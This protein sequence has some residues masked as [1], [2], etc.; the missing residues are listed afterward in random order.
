MSNVTEQ[1]DRIAVVDFG[2]QYAHLIASKVRRIGVLAEIRQPTDP[3]E[4]Y[5]PYRGVIISGSPALASRGED[6]DYDRR[7]LD[8]DV[9]IVGFCF[10]HQE[11]AKHYGGR[12]EH[13]GREYGFARLSITAQ[14]PVF[15]GMGPE[16]TVWMSHQDAVVEVG[17]G[18]SEIGYSTLVEDGTVHRFAAIADE[19]RRRYG[20]QYHPEVD[21]TEHGEDMIRNFVIDVCGCR[22]TWR[23][24][25]FAESEIEEIRR[26]VGD[27]QVLLLVSG[28]VDS[29]VCAVL[30]GRALGPDHLRLL[31]IDNGLMRKGESRK[32]LERFERFGLGGNLHFVDASD[33][34]LDALEGL[35]EPEEKRRAIGNT[36]VQVFEQE[37]VRWIDG[38]VVLA[39]GTIYPDTIETGGTDRADVIKTHHNRVP[40]VEEMIAAGRVVEPIRD[41]YKVEVR[42]LGAELGLDESLLERHPFP[43]PGLG[44][45]LLCADAPP[46]G[47]EE[48]ERTTNLREVLAR[49]GLEGRL[50]PIRSVGVKADL[51]CY[52]LPVVL[53]GEAPDWSAATRAAGAVFKEVEHVN[54]C[55]LDLTGGPVESLELVPAHLTRER[56]DLLREADALIM[57][58]LGRHGLLRSIWQCPTVLAPLRRNRGGDEYVIVR[59]V[60]SARAMTA[61]PARLAEDLVRE[62]REGILALPG[63]SGLGLDVTTKPPGTIEWE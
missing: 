34:F 45:R 15:R 13:T 46:E 41:L 6:E 31:H 24:S 10:G 48:A 44:V 38:D 52:E 8:L 47:F 50:V 58:G 57:E 27:R 42:E 19:E 21:D 36:F 20:F 26:T 49:F 28:G 54:R 11:I 17:E 63:V 61:A 53:H 59:P 1:H 4:A 56:L 14:S 60:H 5:A 32:V 25:A 35:T 2:G 7:I 37:A 62:L 30:L 40:L 55:V 22:P 51:R 23:V 12:V 39:Q 29:T 33:Q 43:G 3:P 16:L 9:P 18:F